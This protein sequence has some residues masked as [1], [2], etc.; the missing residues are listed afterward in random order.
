MIFIAGSS[1]M[2]FS[3]KEGTVDSKVSLVVVAYISKFATF[4][5]EKLKNIKPATTGRTENF[6]IFL[7][8]IY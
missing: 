6:T 3:S 5:V 8:I 1:N 7:L 2:V 4:F